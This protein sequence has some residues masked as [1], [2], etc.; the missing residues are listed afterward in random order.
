MENDFNLFEYLEAIKS[1]NDHRYSEDEIDYSE[2]LINEP[3]QI[4]T[5]I[6]Q[7]PL[8]T[9]NISNYKRNDLHDKIL[10]YKLIYAANFIVEIKHIEKLSVDVSIR[11]TIFQ[12]PN[13]M[14]CK[15]DNHCNLNK[16]MRFSNCQWLK[17]F[18]GSWGKRIPK[19]EMLNIL[20]WLIN[21]ENV[22][23]FI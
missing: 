23:G 11:E 17:Y 1:I 2:L 7:E 9:I 20:Y 16:D 15:M 19:I 21:I 4:I 13:G 5:P 8:G 6:I 12:T 3:D 14:P 22:A 18:N 10:S